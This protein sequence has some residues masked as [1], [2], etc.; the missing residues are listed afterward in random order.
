MDKNTINVELV[1]QI[2]NYMRAEPFDV[3]MATWIDSDGYGISSCGTTGCIAGI[4]CF[5]T[6]EP[7]QSNLAE[8]KKVKINASYHYEIAD[9]ARRLLG[10]DPAKGMGYVFGEQHWPEP[11]YT[12]MRNARMKYFEHGLDCPERAKRRKAMTEI[13]IARLEHLIQTGE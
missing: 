10:L 12:Q 2:I 6:H 5:L 13:T 1:Q 11:F 4:A 3:E 9:R 8:Y 7:K